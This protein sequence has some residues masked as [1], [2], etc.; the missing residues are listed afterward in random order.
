MR[1]ILAAA[2]ALALFTVSGCDINTGPPK[3]AKVECNCATPAPPAGM[4]PSTA[5]APPETPY[6]YRAHRHGYGIARWSGHSYYW[7]REYSEISVATYDYHSDS[8]SYTMAG[9]GGSYGASAYAAAGAYAGGYHAVDHGWVDG[10]GRGHDG[11]ATA[12]TPVHYETNGR[13]GGRG[14]VWHGYDVDCPDGARR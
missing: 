11:G 2:A 14:D 8:H 13:S 3:T 1:V 6:R 7:R 4:R 9:G 10:Y 5:Y 12:G